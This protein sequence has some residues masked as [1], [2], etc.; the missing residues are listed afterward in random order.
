MKPGVKWLERGEAVFGG[1]F[2]FFWLAESSLQHV[3]SLLL[4]TG[5]L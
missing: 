3:G 5:F 2:F 1:L 4:H